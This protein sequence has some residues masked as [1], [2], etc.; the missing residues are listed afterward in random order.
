MVT[1]N[2]PTP[3][4]FRAVR[5]AAR[6]TQEGAG[7]LLEVARRTVQDWEGGRRAIPRGMFEL[8]QIKTGQS[9]EFCRRDPA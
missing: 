7:I 6:L 8:L 3:G 1:S 9:R 2:S 5:R 4:E